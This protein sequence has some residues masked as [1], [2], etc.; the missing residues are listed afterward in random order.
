MTG[1]SFIKNGSDF[2]YNSARNYK[3][4][5]YYSAPFLNEKDKER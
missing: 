4:D 3:E 1:I 5:N 2:L